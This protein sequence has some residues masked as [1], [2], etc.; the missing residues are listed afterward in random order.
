MRIIGFIACIFT[1]GVLSSPAIAAMWELETTTLP[2]K[3]EYPEGVDATDF[4]GVLNA[5]NAYINAFAAE[6]Y[7]TMA[8]LVIFSSK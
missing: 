4:E 3:S 1:C 8:D 6:D 2:P 7:L 5:Y